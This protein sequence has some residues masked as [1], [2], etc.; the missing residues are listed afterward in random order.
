ML[1][2]CNFIVLEI[3]FPRPTQR[4]F[5]LFSYSL[6]VL[7]YVGVSS[8]FL[9]CTIQMDIWVVSHPLP[10]NILLPWLMGTYAISLGDKGVGGYSPKQ[11]I[12]G[13]QGNVF[14]IPIDTAKSPPQV[15]AT[16][17][18]HTLVSLWSCQQVAYSNLDFC[19]SDEWKIVSKCDLNLYLSYEYSWPCFHVV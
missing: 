2:S 4:A 19:Q 11:G 13:S 15:R 10:L 9:T 8:F 6:V 1:F 7:H 14:V 17:C 18:S 12:T 3:F 16:L 5:L